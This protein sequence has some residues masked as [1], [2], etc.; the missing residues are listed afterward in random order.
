MKTM[1]FKVT[2]IFKKGDWQVWSSLSH[3]FY[4]SVLGMI[5]EQGLLETIL[6]HMEENKVIWDNKYGFTKVSPALPTFW[7][8]TMA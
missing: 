6:M 1:D 5:I 7:S 2:P 3:S 4:P 8:S